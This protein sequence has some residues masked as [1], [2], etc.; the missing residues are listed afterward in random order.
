MAVVVNMLKFMGYAFALAASLAAL[1]TLLGAPWLSWRVAGW[2]AGA[3]ISCQL[4][5]VVIA[6]L[7][8]MRVFR[9]VR[10][11]YGLKPRQTLSLLRLQ[12]EGRGDEIEDKLLEY[13]VRVVKEDEL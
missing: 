5:I 12:R 2:M 13:H 3:A 8:V 9:V 7:G 1:G 10:R 6:T 4:I 11:N